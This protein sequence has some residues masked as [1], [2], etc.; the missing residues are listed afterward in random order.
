MDSLEFRSNM[1]SAES[2]L[3]AWN[4]VAF[5]KQSPFLQKNPKTPELLECVVKPGDK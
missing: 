2:K 4:A 5:C 3:A 1:V